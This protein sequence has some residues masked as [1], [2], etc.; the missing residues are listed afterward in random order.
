[1]KFYIP[2]FF[3]ILNAQS[4]CAQNYVDIVKIS[5]GTTS[6]NK[7]DSS[8]VSTSINEINADITYPIKINENNSIITGIIYEGIQTKLFDTLDVKII[9]SITLKVG[10]NK[11]FNENWTGTFVVLPKISSDFVQMNSHDVQI[12]GI[13][14]FKYKK[15]ENLNYKI[16]L[17]YNSELFGPFFVPMMG[18]YYLSPSKKFETNLMLPLQADLNYKIFP[19]M[20]LGFNFNGQIRTYHLTNVAPSINSAYV[21]KSTNEF[22]AY[23]KFNF[24]K[25]ICFL[26]KVGYSIGRSYRV[27]NENDKVNFGLPATFIGPKRKQL[28]DDFSDGLL[29]Q[30]GLLYRFS[31]E[32]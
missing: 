17:Y 23:L 12:G 19:F 9:S 31:L 8:N 26:T 18:L 13:A 20:N 6:P 7:F 5:A 14:I 1:M 16:G 28:N 21:A 3:L 27:Y 30:I 24:G 10:L 32:K 11:K 15:N 25:S 22:F 2:I 29:L 4:L